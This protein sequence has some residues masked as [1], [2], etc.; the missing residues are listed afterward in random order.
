[1]EKFI[2]RLALVTNNK[3]KVMFPYYFGNRE[4]ALSYAKIYVNVN[5]DY[6]MNALEEYCNSEHEHNTCK[7]SLQEGGYKRLYDFELLYKDNRVS[8]NRY[9]ALTRVTVFCQE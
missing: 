3:V 2:Y 8:Y 4:T 5:Q 1:M 6:L 7:C 9:L